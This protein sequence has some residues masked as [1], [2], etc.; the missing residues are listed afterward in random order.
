MSDAT[1]QPKQ[2]SLEAAADGNDGPVGAEPTAG[3]ERRRRAGSVMTALTLP[4]IVAAVLAL[5]LWFVLFGGGSLLG[6]EV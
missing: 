1:D 6:T 4:E 5:G 3:L 2:R